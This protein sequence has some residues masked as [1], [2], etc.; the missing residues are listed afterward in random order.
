[1]KIMKVLQM[2]ENFF[3]FKISNPMIKKLDLSIKKVID[4]YKVNNI[5]KSVFYN[6]GNG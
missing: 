3:Q 1:M 6:S 2:R 4:S 5:K